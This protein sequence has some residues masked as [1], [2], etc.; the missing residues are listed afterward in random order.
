MVDL[1]MLVRVAISF[2]VS[3]ACDLPRVTRTKT[4][5]STLGFINFM[6]VSNNGRDFSG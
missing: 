6:V 1:V 5:T 4:T 2:P 3:F